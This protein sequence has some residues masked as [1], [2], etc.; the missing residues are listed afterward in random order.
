M[1]A[2][3]LRGSLA[4]RFGDDVDIIRDRESFPDGENWQDFIKQ[5]LARPN[6]MVFALMGENWAAPRIL[7]PDGNRQDW[8]RIELEL[9]IANKARVIPVLVDR[10][11]MP[12]ETQLPTSVKQLASINA[13]R[14]RDGDWD[15]DVE[16]LAKLVAPRSSR[17]RPWAIAAAAA[18]VVVVAGASFA[19]YDYFFDSP[20]IAE[21][22]STAARTGDIGAIQS[23]LGR[24]MQ[25]DHA[26]DEQ[27]NTMAHIAAGN[28]RLDAMRFLKTNGADLDRRNLVQ[29]TPLGIAK[30]K[31]PADQLEALNALLA[32]TFQ[33]TPTFDGLSDP[34]K[35]LQS[36]DRGVRVAARDALARMG[37][38]AVPQIKCQ[39][40]NDSQRQRVNV[41]RLQLGV[42]EA[43]TNMGSDP[44]TL[45]KIS[46]NLTNKDMAELRGFAASG[47]AALKKC[48]S[49]LVEKVSTVRSQR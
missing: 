41:Y 42:C 48:A 1:A 49:E 26:I 7:D 33:C 38:D 46:A 24:G 40:R 14:L 25:P 39:L 31:C 2:G 45:Q 10:D 9:A 12:D 32:P 6:V 23:I 35:R 20:S 16:R 37:P 28:C 47:D 15:T 44:S 29:G 34:F 43:L 8:N 22:A 4:A 36:D 13:L 27:G 21:L 17:S 3:R 19:A 30:A 5:E 18:A 11:E